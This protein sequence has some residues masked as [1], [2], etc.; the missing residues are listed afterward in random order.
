MVLLR[1]IAELT[2]EAASRSLSSIAADCGK[3]IG[4]VIAGVFRQVGRLFFQQD[5]D[6]VRLCMQSKIEF[7]RRHPHLAP[8]LI[9]QCLLVSGEDHRHGAHPGFDSRA[10]C[11]ALVRRLISNRREGAS[12]IEQQIVRVIT[13]RF[14]RTLRRKVREVFLAS[15]VASHFPKEQI[16]SVYLLIGYYGWRMNNYRQA[17][18]RLCLSPSNLSL[19][20]AS[21]IVARLKYPE[22]QVTPLSRSDQIALRKQ[23]LKRLYSRHINDGAYAYL[24]VIDRGC[25]IPHRKI[26]SEA[27]RTLS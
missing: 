12:T 1:R 20:G 3:R 17:C 26:S 23:H 7:L 21:D 13:N 27:C 5:W 19:D 25:S 22:P 18:R 2:P 15:L 8:P 10:I 24:G 16:P 4:T 6:N 11:R 9:V 14:E